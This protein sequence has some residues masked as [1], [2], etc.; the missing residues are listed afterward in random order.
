MLAADMQEHQPRH[1]TLEVF[2]DNGNTSH[3]VSNERS[4]K[5]G[6]ASEDGSKVID[7]AHDTVRTAALPIPSSYVNIDSTTS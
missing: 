5:R 4:E 2:L 1:I 7:E 3:S 6:T